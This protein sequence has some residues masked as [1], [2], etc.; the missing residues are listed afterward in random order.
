M[1]S[2]CLVVATLVGALPSRMSPPHLPRSPSVMA[3]SLESVTAVAELTSADSA[4]TD[5][6]V[7]GIENVPDALIE[8]PFKT[9]SAGAAT[10]LG[11]A[12]MVVPAGIVRVADTRTWE[13]RMYEIFVPRA[14]LEEY[15]LD[16]KVTFESSVT[17]GGVRAALAALEVHVAPAILP[18]HASHE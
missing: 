11:S 7:I 15:L 9:T 6:N 16:S 17:N 8:P 2:I 13:A 3:F 12:K 1:P 10:P 5:V 14:V 4:S 18:L